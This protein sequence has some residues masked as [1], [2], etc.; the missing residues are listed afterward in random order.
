MRSANFPG[1]VQQPAGKRGGCGSSS[2]R[3]N[4]SGSSTLRGCCHVGVIIF[5]DIQYQ[6]RYPAHSYRELGV[7]IGRS[8]LYRA[9]VGQLPTTYWQ[10]QGRVAIGV[11]VIWPRR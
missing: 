7:I 9:M 3:C 5:G 8:T 11:G 6:Q 2:G 10:G 4:V 1:V